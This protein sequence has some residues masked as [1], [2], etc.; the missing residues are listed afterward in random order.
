MHRRAAGRAGT[1]RGEAACGGRVDL[2]APVSQ[3]SSSGRWPAEAAAAAAA[4][5]QL[6]ANPSAEQGQAAPPAAPAGGSGSEAAV[7]SC[8]SAPA[9][10]ARGLAGEQRVIRHEKVTRHATS[11]A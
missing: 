9:C 1:G 8:A 2:D 10:E 4:A 11:R 5:S 7:R 6:A 3:G